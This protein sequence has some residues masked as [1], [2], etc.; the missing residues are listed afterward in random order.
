MEETKD[1]NG[2]TLCPRCVK[3]ATNDKDI[4][5]SDLESELADPEDS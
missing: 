5:V 4:S 3:D 2:C 1:A